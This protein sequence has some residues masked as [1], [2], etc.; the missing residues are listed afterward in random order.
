MSKIEVSHQE[1]YERLIAVE[2]KV[3][4]IDKNTAEVVE[5]FTAAKGAFTVLELLGKLAKPL[6]W[7]GG[8]MT[9]IGIIWQ[10]WKGH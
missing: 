6:M 3:D 10:N 1:I 8:L 9:A 5:L 7:I 2:S 4:R